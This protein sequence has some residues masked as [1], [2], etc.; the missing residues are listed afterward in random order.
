MHDLPPIP[1]HATPFHCDARLEWVCQIPRGKSTAYL[2]IYRSRI[3]TTYLANYSASST[4]NLFSFCSLMLHAGKAPKNPDWY[5]PGIWLKVFLSWVIS[6]T[7]MNSQQRALCF[8]WPPRDFS[9]LWRGWVLVCGRAS[10]YFWRSTSLL[11]SKWQQACRTEVHDFCSKALQAPRAGKLE[12]NQCA[13]GFGGDHFCCSCS[14]THFLCIC[15]IHTYI[16]PNCESFYRKMFVKYILLL[17]LLTVGLYL[18]FFTN[19]LQCSASHST[20][21]VQFV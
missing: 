18:R 21:I 14:S 4:Q 11:P 12:E 17:E 9:L 13:T 6:T 7:A 20:L 1:F 8:S 5:N 15:K 16:L 3:Y 2:S 10:A 19:W